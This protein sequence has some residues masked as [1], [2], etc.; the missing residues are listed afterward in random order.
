M[1]CNFSSKIYKKDSLESLPCSTI[2]VHAKKKLNHQ[3]LYIILKNF[4]ESESRLQ[5][6]VTNI[7]FKV[8]EIQDFTCACMVFDLEHYLLESVK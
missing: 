6:V 3:S 5:S 4:Y 7:C 1:F 2:D 8:L